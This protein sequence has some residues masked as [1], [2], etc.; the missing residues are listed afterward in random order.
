VQNLTHKF[1]FDNR[2]WTSR[3]KCVVS[4][5]YSMYCRLKQSDPLLA[6]WTS[7]NPLAI[8]YELLPYSFVFDWFLNIGGYMR[9]LETALRYSSSFVSGYQSLIVST[10]I[11]TT[12]T[13]AQRTSGVAYAMRGGGS[14]EDLEFSRS[15]LSSY[16]APG[17]PTLSVDLGS[18]RLLSAAA[19]L[20][21]ML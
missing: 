4:V 17:F 6:R 9:G 21:Q 7:L 10:R 5:G 8:G 19:L 3:V 20:R 11:S 12:I 13:E 16:P 14:R 15:V 1:P 2:N 18:G